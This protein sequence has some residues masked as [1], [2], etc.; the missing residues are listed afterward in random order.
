MMMEVKIGIC[1]LKVGEDK[2]LNLKRAGEMIEESVQAG[3]EIVV[4][5]EMFNCPYQQEFFPRLAEEEAD[6]PTVKLLSDLAREKHCYIIGGSIPERDR[7]RIYNT[8]F[9]FDRQG[10]RIAKHQKMHLF[11]INLPGR[12]AFQESAILSPGNQVTSFDT[13]FGRIGLAICYDIRF[14]ELFRLLVNRGVIAVI[15]PAAFN[16]T[17]GPAH[18]E[19]LFRT[20]AIDNQVFMIGVGPA[21][22][23]QAGYQS[24]GHSLVV[25]PWGEV[26]WQAGEEETV[27]IVTIN[28]DKVAQIRAELPLLNH[29]RLDLYEVRELKNKPS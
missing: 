26:L 1:Q 14:P 22:N 17:T 29:R 12:I 7:E 27:G 21:R 24:Y 25:D 9:V 2:N 13:E 10:Q 8:S 20:R 3:A 28:T 6:G 5:P 18:W 11:D 15:V 4:L 23:H 19:T 16:T